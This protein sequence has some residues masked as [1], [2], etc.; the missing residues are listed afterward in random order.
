MMFNIHN[1]RAKVK[2]G[3][4]IRRRKLEDCRLF[5]QFIQS[6]VDVSVCIL[7]FNV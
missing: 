7:K 1:R 4:L 2:A 6:V 3:A 5:M